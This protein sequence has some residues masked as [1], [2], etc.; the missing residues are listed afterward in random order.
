MRR[1][2]AATAALLVLAVGC[3]V[4]TSVEACAPAATCST[5]GPTLRVVL[6][7]LALLAAAAA[8]LLG[9]AIVRALRATEAAATALRR[10]VMPTPPELAAAAGTR[11]LPPVLCM[12]SESPTALCAG[13]LRP[14]IFVSHGLVREL[15]SVELRAVLIHEAG[16]ARRRDPLRRQ[17]R[18]SVAAA[19]FFAPLVQWWAERQAIR[20]ELRAD[21]AA[22]EACGPEPLARA[23]LL[24]APGP[25]RAAAAIDGAASVRVSHLLGDAVG[26]PA[27]P[28]HVW[29]VSVGALLA[30]AVVAFCSA[31]AVVGPR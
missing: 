5:P 19:L 8:L 3:I 13:G 16:H 14:R 6:P 11:S 24:T 4:D 12:E 17:V 20:D 7:A 2:R 10:L 23:L 31:V 29:L 21:R 25:A 18:Q 9:I 26:L 15:S 28:M 1:R 27:P 22:I 30:A